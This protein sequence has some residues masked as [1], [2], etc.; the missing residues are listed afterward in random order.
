MAQSTAQSRQSRTPG[1]VKAPKG[2]KRKRHNPKASAH[3]IARKTGKS[4]GKRNADI[5][6][7]GLMKHPDWREAAEEALKTLNKG[8]RVTSQPAERKAPW[9]FSDSLKPIPPHRALV[10]YLPPSP[11]PPSYS[12][13]TIAA[14]AHRSDAPVVQWL[15]GYEGTIPLCSVAVISGK[16]GR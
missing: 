6:L 4:A 14:G 10:P 11:P 13:H 9:T 12:R 8:G 7:S 2:G 3:K 1:S 5:E 15:H 16:S